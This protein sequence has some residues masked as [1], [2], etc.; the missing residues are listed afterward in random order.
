MQQLVL[1]RWYLGHCP[2]SDEQR[3]RTMIRQIV[4]TGA[5]PRS[6]SKRTIYH[7]DLS[8]MCCSKPLLAEFG[9]A[10]MQQLVL[11]RWYLGHCPC[12]G[13]QRMRTMIRQIV[14]TGARPRSMSKRTIYHQDLSSMCCSKPLLAKFG[15]GSSWLA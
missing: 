5:R 8:S 2:C 4:G 7:Q 3:M 1:F 14:G 10:I 13:E 6:M 12:S 15:T 9:T 11:F